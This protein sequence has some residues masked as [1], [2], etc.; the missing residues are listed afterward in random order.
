VSSPSWARRPPS[1]DQLKIVGN[2]TVEPNGLSKYRTPTFDPRVWVAGSERRRPLLPRSEWV[3]AQG[4]AAPRRACSEKLRIRGGCGPERAA[5]QGD[6]RRG[7]RAASRFH[8]RA[9]RRCASRARAR[10]RSARRFAAPSFGQLTHATSGALRVTANGASAGGPAEAAPLALVLRPRPVAVRVAAIVPLAC[11]VVDLPTPE[12][13]GR[14]AAEPGLRSARATPLP[15]RANACA[16][17]AA[18]TRQA[19]YAI[20]HRLGQRT[21]IPAFRRRALDSLRVEALKRPPA[22]EDK[23]GE[24]APCPGLPR[25]ERIDCASRGRARTKRPKPHPVPGPRGVAAISSDC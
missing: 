17:A 16:F 12:G 24:A 2:S 22:R 19:R 20:E 8:C 11:P 21:A 14:G 3:S 13:P 18:N 6:A 4:C 15:R 10:T 7:P 1:P 5:R 9:A 23:A 25:K